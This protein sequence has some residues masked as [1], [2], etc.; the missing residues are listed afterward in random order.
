MSIKQQEELVPTLMEALF[1]LYQRKREG[2][3]VSDINL[4]IR[5]QVFRNIEPLPM[6][7][8]EL[9][10]FVVGESCHVA[11]QKLA[12]LYPDR[13]EVE[14]E[15][16]YKDIV[17]HIDLYD[18]ISNVCFE[19]KTSRSSKT[20]DLP[21]DFQVQ[22]LKCYMA[23]TDS[24]QG[25]ILYLLM[26]NFDEPLFMEFPITMTDKE[27][28]DQKAW[29]ETNAQA[30]K[31]GLEKKNAEFAPHIFYNPKLNWKCGKTY[32]RKDKAGNV[33]SSKYYKSCKYYDQCETM[34]AKERKQ[35][36]DNATASGV[37]KE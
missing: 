35:L 27:I 8:R 32:E 5:E 28:A 21:K 29:M 36:W 33:V 16:W 13:F 22:Q 23:M 11:A 30:F 24:K 9:N 37:V 10:Y 20:D 26:N 2:V 6:T 1:D 12:K 18:K 25:Y 3:H 17:A 15:V 34:R 19:L 7:V 4:C 31:F 14:K